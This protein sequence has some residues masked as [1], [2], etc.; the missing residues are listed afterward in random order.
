MSERRERENEEASKEGER[1]GKRRWETNN[2]RG[3][4]RENW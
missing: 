3:G 4:E 1:W 2:G